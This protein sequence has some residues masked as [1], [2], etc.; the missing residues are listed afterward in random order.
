MITEVT[1]GTKITEN[2]LAARGRPVQPVQ[3]LIKTD[4]HAAHAA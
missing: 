1:E 2:K 4:Y 3:T